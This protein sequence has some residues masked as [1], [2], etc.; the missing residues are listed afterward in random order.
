MN[1]MSNILVNYYLILIQEDRE[2]WVVEIK[3]DIKEELERLNIE[4][5]VLQVLQVDNKLFIPNGPAIIV[6]L[7][8]ESARTSD[9][10]KN[11]LNVAREA[12]MHI[13]PVF[14][15]EKFSKNVPS[16]LK[17][18]NGFQWEN[19]LSSRNLTSLILRELGL[20]EKE[21]K[22]FLSYRHTDGQFIA[23]QF[24]DTLTHK[25]FD[26]FLDRYSIQPGKDFPEKIWE[27]LDEKA[28]ILVIET[29][30]AHLSDWLVREV[31][32]GLKSHMGFLILTMPGVTQ[33]IP[34]TK[35]LPRFILKPEDLRYK[36]EFNIIKSSIIEKI[37]IQIEFRH[38]E[39][40][41]RRNRNLRASL[42]KEYSKFYGITQMRDWLLYLEPKNA[43]KQS[44]M[45]KLSPRTPKIDDL[46]LLN[47]SPWR[48]LNI[49]ESRRVVVH[50]A[51]YYPKIYGL[52]FNWIS[53]EVNIKVIRN[54]SEM[55]DDL[56]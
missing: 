37:L 19:M 13:I 36:G 44:T 9:R 53:N 25:G 5:G 24:F 33:R 31:I 11:L 50:E 14:E 43:S 28:F 39:G 54:D 23:N 12:N 17:E 41:L 21:R 30:E 38:A 49:D 4:T 34:N 51:K 52:V 26:V 15:K 3:K 48:E 22:I 42:I 56:L 18:I 47:E 40:I 6:F 55:L 45:I 35:D 2:N 10:C 29:I 27:S 1:P 46:Y 20:T 7:G 8:S 16:L 32:H